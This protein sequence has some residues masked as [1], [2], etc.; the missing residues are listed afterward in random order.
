LETE[1][2]WVFLA[3]LPTVLRL[4]CRYAFSLPL[5]LSFFDY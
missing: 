4:P 3:Y 2:P 1:S 5:F